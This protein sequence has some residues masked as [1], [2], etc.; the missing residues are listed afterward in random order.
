MRMPSGGTAEVGC[1]P[2]CPM[3]ATPVCLT[4]N[5][6][7]PLSTAFSNFCQVR[8]RQ[9]PLTEANALA[10]QHGDL[11]LC[12]VFEHLLCSCHAA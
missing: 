3:A 4:V 2:A 12:V 7:L 6:R 5:N 10:L 11:R 8:V 9:L 1:R